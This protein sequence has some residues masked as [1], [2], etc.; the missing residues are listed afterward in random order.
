MNEDTK[1]VST[2]G[3]VTESA[4]VTETKTFDPGTLSDDVLR[5][6]DQERTRASRTARE[7]AE[8]KLRSDE[9]FKQSLRSELEA[10]AK[11]SAEEKLAKEREEVAEERKLARLEKNTLIVE[12]E[13]GK[14]NLDDEAL[15]KFSSFLTT[16]SEETT[17]ERV[18]AFVS[19]FTKVIE[20]HKAEVT[21]DM[22]KGTI[23]PEVNGSSATE[24]S[25]L[26]AQYKE[27][28]AK[29][30][31]IAMARIIREAQTKN[32]QINF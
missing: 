8:M 16:D 19:E 23:T 9:T 25:L 1:N 28:V 10:E 14:L 18:G 3:T 15:A 27:A 17:R 7:R 24:A 13:L 29:N 32:I 30:D 11:M 26:E 4:T 20:T 22:L 5:Y 2:E 31:Q 6:I 12:K 21:K